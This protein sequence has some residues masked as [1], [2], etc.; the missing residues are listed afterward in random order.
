MGTGREAGSFYTPKAFWGYTMYIDYYGKLHGHFGIEDSTTPGIHQ[1]QIETTSSISLG[2]WMMITMTYN[3]GQ[4]ADSIN[5]HI[6]GVSQ[7]YTVINNETLS[8]GNTNTSY[9]NGA[10]TMGAVYASHNHPLKGSLDEAAIWDRKL[11]QSEIDALYNSGN[12]LQ[13]PF[14]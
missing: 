11:N 7:A 6:N 14:V 12:A 10:L 3:G 5:L 2:T 4:H 13:Y 9:V 8:I 1:F